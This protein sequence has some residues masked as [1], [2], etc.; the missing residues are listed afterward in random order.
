M[1]SDQAAVGADTIH[2]VQRV[3]QNIRIESFQSG[4][5]SVRHETSITRER[6]REDVDQTRILNCRSTLSW[7]YLMHCLLIRVVLP[8]HDINPVVYHLVSGDSR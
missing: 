5:W 1:T 7:L 2:P 6:F 4:S 3:I 8:Y